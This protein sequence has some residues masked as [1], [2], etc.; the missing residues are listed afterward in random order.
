MTDKQT[1]EP[2]DPYEPS[3]ASGTLHHRL[4]P[5]LFCAAPGVS[6]HAERAQAMAHNQWSLP[7]LISIIRESNLK[8]LSSRSK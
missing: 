4:A 5:E 8:K 2:S 6:L 7:Y 3:E 1:Y